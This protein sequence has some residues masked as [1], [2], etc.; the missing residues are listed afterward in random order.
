[1]FVERWIWLLVS[2]TEGRCWFVN[3]LLPGYYSCSFV[4]GRDIPLPGRPLPGRT[5]APVRVQNC[6]CSLDFSGNYSKFWRGSESN[7]P[8]CLSRLKCRGSSSYESGM[9]PPEVNGS[10]SLSISRRCC[11]S[12]LFSEFFREF[13]KAELTAWPDSPSFSTLPFVR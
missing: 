2:V 13:K 9:I 10:D 6:S 7:C 3:M 5:S 4:I 1:M 8:E 11:S 12:V